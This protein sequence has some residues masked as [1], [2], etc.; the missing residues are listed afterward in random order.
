MCPQ[1]YG[2]LIVSIIDVDG[3]EPLD[4]ILYGYVYEVSAMHRKIAFVLSLLLAFFLGAT[5]YATFSGRTDFGAGHEAA[6]V[7]NADLQGN[8][9]AGM[10]GSANSALPTGEGVLGPDPSEEIVI[11]VYEKVSPSV[12]HITAVRQAL[13][14]F[15]GL[16]P[17][18]GTGSGVII[19]SQGYILTNN[20]VIK[21]AQDV[22]VRFTDGTFTEAKVVGI[23]QFTD[24]AVIK[25]DKEVD[26]SWVAELGDSDK[27]RVG[28]KAIAIGNPFGFDSTLSV[29]VVSALGRPIKTE[30]AEYDDMI[31]TDASINP[32]NS[33]GP[34][35]NSSGQVI[36]INTGIFSK[37]GTNL[38]IGFSIPSNSCRKVAEDLIKFGRVRRPYLGAQV[39]ALDKNIARELSLAV[40][41]GLL[42]QSVT[43]DSPAAKA[44]IKAGG[45]SIRLHYGFYIFDI[46]MGGDVI[47][48]LDGEAVYNESQLNNKIK[49]MGPGDVVKL[50]ILRN[51]AT[52][53]VNVT[54]EME[55]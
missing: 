21:D 12:V 13:T 4:D 46:V 49:K 3:T 22:T 44:G 37:T 31:Q 52:M 2:G 36:G 23:D 6:S 45:S 50:T 8:D 32:G 29:G 19:S 14:P 24:L 18:E 51:G 38:G 28:Q 41:N 55:P 34:L 43:P 53:D 5:T 7:G 30:A 48:A 11:N 17:Q 54:L 10:P 20:H 26:A 35:I 27:L 42:V 33:G 47:L 15:W 39:F 16:V 9:E 25:A 40:N 1:T